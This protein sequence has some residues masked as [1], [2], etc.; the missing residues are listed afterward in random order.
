MHTKE[1]LINDLRNMGLTGEEA[2]MVHSSMK[3]IGAVDGGADTVV[4]AFMEFL[5][6][7]CL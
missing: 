4:D 1:A 6:K 3:T 7:D 5:K 2:I